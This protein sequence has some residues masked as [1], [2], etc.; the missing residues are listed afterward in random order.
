MF[1]GG[2]FLKLGLD[3]RRHRGLALPERQNAISAFNTPPPSQSQKP[4]TL[5]TALSFF[6]TVIFAK[7][8]FAAFL[9]FFVAVGLASDRLLAPAAF[10]KAR[11]VCFSI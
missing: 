8:F 2:K 11:R 7:P 3:S 1:S 5:P 4:M 10:D 9:A 6:F